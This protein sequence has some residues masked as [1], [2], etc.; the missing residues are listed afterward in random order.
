MDRQLRTRIHKCSFR[1]VGRRVVR[2]PSLPYSISDCRRG[3]WGCSPS[4]L[5][6]CIRKT[7]VALM[8]IQHNTASGRPTDIITA[9][10]GRLIFMCAFLSR[11]Q[12]S[13]PFRACPPARRPK[14]F[15]ASVMRPWTG[16]GGEQSRD[17]LQGAAASRKV[18][19]RVSVLVAHLHIRAGCSTSWIKCQASSGE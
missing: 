8:W 18:Q 2:L 9:L 1:V 7:S 16:R 12:A 4:P 17:H 15:T 6:A 13:V 11:W 10:P 5:A 14:N 19:G 3:S